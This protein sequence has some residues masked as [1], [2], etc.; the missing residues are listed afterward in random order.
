MT[1]LNGVLNAASRTA[2]SS[3]DLAIASGQIIARR[4]ALGMAAAFDPLQADHAEFGRMMPEKM[5]AFLA[6]G[7]IMLQ[8]T[9]QA[10][11]QIVRFASDAMIT[12]TEATLA[13]AGCTSSAAMVETQGN[14]VL[15]SLN[16]AASNFFA[17][18]IT[19]LGA[20]E[21]AMAPI[22]KT[23]AANAERLGR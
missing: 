13:M 18:G 17:V 5:E 1:S 6:A 22:R 16:S 23:V 2:S 14:F 19:A 15:A 9:K 4:F 20:H 3:S 21:A 8:Q 12:A 7:V 11:E 10:G